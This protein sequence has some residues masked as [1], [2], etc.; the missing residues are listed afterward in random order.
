MRLRSRRSSRVLRRSK[1]SKSLEVARKGR[2]RYPH[3]WGYCF[4]PCVRSLIPK[5]LRTKRRP[6]RRVFIGGTGVL[7]VFLRSIL[8]EQATRPAMLSVKRRTDGVK[9]AGGGNL[10]GTASL[11]GWQAFFTS[12]EFSASS[13]HCALGRCCPCGR[14][15]RPR[16]VLPVVMPESLRCTAYRPPVSGL[17]QQDSGPRGV[18][19]SFIVRREAKSLAGCGIP[20]SQCVNPG[21]GAARQGAAR[22]QSASRSLAQADNR[23]SRCKSSRCW[24][25]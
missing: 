10:R 21:A 16:H 23:R 18:Y 1:S 17:E 2:T 4:C 22:S 9:L 13:I 24:E 19:S 3:S 6:I 14:F 7:R 5:P 12:A 11:E 8:R 20:R 25:R 15:R